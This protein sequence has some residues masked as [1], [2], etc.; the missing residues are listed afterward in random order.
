MV[1][2]IG[3]HSRTFIHPAVTPPWHPAST[4]AS[5]PS[6]RLG[7]RRTRLGARRT[8]GLPSRPHRPHR[9]PLPLFAH[10]LALSQQH[11][12]PSPHPTFSSPVDSSRGPR[13]RVHSFAQASPLARS[14]SCH[15]APVTLPPF[16]PIPP[17]ADR[18]PSRLPSTLA[19]L[20]HGPLTPRRSPWGLTTRHPRQSP[21]PSRA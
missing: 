7:A 6:T 11:R 20:T 8:R 14:L 9:N 5:I 2:L 15:A 12:W 17:P 21:A 4:L 18:P 1:R 10:R 16:I 3:P 19:S 13:A